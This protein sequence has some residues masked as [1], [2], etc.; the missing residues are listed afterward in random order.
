MTVTV[1]IFEV[2]SSLSLMVRVTK[3]V[4]TSENNDGEN[5]NTVFAPLI[6]IQAG[7]GDQSKVIVCPERSE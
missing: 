1:K 7:Y 5:F 6:D 4:P 2:E 3:W